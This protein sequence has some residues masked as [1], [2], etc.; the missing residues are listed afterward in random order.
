[1]P[2]K[3]KASPVKKK[4]NLFGDDEED[5]FQVKKV[6]KPAAAKA[7]GNLFGDDDDE[8]FPV[9]TKNKPKNKKK[10]FDDSD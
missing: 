6:S 4:N 1:M 7:K 9:V 10:L 3:P 5:N 8:S 2:A